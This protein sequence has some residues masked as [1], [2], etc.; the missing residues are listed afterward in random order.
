MKLLLKYVIIMNMCAILIICSAVSYQLIQMKNTIRYCIYWRVEYL[1]N[2][3]VIV[4]GVT[5]IWQ[6]VVAAVHII[7][8]KIYWHYVNFEDK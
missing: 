6:K 8:M 5:L 4:V 7:A 3:S 2:W 1:T